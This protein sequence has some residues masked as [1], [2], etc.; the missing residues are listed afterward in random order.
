MIKYYDIEFFKN[1]FYF[2][3]FQS[4]LI[5]L[6][7]FYAISLFVHYLISITI[8]IYIYHQIELLTKTSLTFSLTL[9]LYRL[10]ILMCLG[11]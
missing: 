1:N 10:S 8:Y 11:R 6:D 3:T 9:I 2:G 5:Q 7:A 4:V